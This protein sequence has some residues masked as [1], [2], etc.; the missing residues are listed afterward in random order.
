MCYC[1]FTFF[2]KNTRGLELQ[3]PIFVSVIIPVYNCEKYIGAAIESV[4]SQNGLSTEIIVV[5]DGST[6][7]SIMIARDY[8]SQINIIQQSNKGACEAR[9]AGVSMASGVFIK[10]LDADDYLIPDALRAQ[11]AHAS[12]LSDQQFSYGRVYRHIEHDGRLV[13]HSSRDGKSDNQ[14]SADKMIMDPPV[15]SSFLYSKN[16]LNVLGGFDQKLSKREDFDLFARALYLGFSPV[17]CTAPICAYRDHDGSGRISKRSS[18]SIFNN[19]L[20][21]FCRHKLLLEKSN[22]A[23]NLGELRL[24]L[25][26]TIWI[27]GRNCLRS[28]FTEK[29]VEFFALAK[30]ICGRKAVVGRPLYRG[31]TGLIGPVTSESIIRV[32]KSLRS[33]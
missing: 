25:G 24:G 33:A 15:T 31:V 5:D 22:T 19:Q 17:A 3:N 13:P 16:L 14:D 10:F 18:L 11:Y 29:S 20:E 23:R 7:S 30:E 9:N 1:D 21:M 32:L 6:D 2:L 27:T 26:R 4:L 12:N 28:G 8:G